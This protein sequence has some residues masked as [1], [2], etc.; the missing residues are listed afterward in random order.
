MIDHPLRIGF[1]PLADAAALIVAVDK[2]FTRPR[3]SMS[4]WSGKC[5]G[6]MS[7]TS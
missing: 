3:G 6:R 7:A 1:I 5:R 4:N 2:G